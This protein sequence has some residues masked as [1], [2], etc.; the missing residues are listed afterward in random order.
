MSTIKLVVCDMAGTT[1]KDERRI[2]QMF[3]M[4]QKKQGCD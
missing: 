1:V 2:E 3:S 4:R